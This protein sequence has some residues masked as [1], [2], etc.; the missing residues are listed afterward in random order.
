MMGRHAATRFLPGVIALAA[1][2]TPA[3][4]DAERSPSYVE[5]SLLKLGRGAA[6]MVTAPAELLRTI[7]R[8]SRR[9]GNLAAFTVG[10][11]QGVGRSLLR[12]LAGI[13]EVGTF[14]VEVPKGFAPIIRPEFVWAHGDWAP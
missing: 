3:W 1:V 13:V 2:A 7:D 10:V 4:A 14:C 8:V 5:G 9:D 11:T 6:N 12:E